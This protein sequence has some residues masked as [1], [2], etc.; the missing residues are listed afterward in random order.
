MDQYDD[1]NLRSCVLKVDLK[2]PK[3]LHESHNDYPLAPDKL[4]IKRELSDFQFQITNDFNISI[5]NVK[6]LV[7]NFF[8]KGKY[9]I[10]Y[11]SSVLKSK[12]LGPYIKFITHKKNIEA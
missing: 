3:E 5:D 2:Y 9:V 8:Q 12:W 10:H 4:Q 6:K 1:E 7:P 11:K